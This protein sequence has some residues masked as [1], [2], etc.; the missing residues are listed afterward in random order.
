MRQL[1]PAIVTEDERVLARHRLESLV[2]AAPLILGLVLE[3][4]RVTDKLGTHPD[5]KRAGNGYAS[6]GVGE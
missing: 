4:L 3:L 2:G 6:V 5:S 1:P